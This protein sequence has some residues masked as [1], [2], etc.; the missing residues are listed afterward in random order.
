MFDRLVHD[1]DPVKILPNYSI[2]VK[3]IFGCTR[4]DSK[5]N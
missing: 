4:T 1:N 5:G 3:I 2:F